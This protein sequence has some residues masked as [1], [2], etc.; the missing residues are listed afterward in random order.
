MAGLDA[1]L[2]GG[3]PQGHTLLVSGPTGSGKTVLGT[4]Y[5]QAGA[6]AGEHGV[7]MY[8]EKHSA[9]LRNA[10]LVDLVRNGQ[11][12][13]LDPRSL[14]LTVE[15]LLD[16]L[17]ET[18]ERTG[19]TRVLIDSLSEIDLY[20]AP[21]FRHDLRLSV[22]R[23]L[24]MLA[25]RGVT[26]LITAGF[27]DNQPNM[28]FSFDDMCFLADAVLALRFAEVDGRLHKFMTVVKVRGC[29]HSTELRGYRIS[30]R[31]IEVDDHVAPYDRILSGWPV[32]R[33]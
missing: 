30:E 21:E 23:T 11:V 25:D 8:F 14:S 4:R 17:V 5:L 32:V 31:G 20:L 16:A 13:V 29:A 15:E 24:S 6:D 10:I 27:E 7:A 1:M 3:I 33:T 28:R 22:F 9:H 2:Y 18:I 26:V 12:T 19:A